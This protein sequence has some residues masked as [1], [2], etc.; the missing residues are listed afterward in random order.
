MNRSRR[1][2][3]GSLVFFLIAVLAVVGVTK[4]QGQRQVQKQPRIVA[5]TDALVAIAAKLDLKLVGVPKTANQL[6]KR[7][8]HVAKIG[9]PMAPNIEK[10]AALKPTDVYAVSVLK[11]QYSDAFKAQKFHPKFLSLNT[12]ADLKHTLTT[13]GQKFDRQKQAQHQIALIDAAQAQAKKRI[14]GPKTKVL[15][16][17]GMPG[18]GYMIATD[19]SYVGDL[20]KKAG[21]ENVYASAA[22][23][24][25]SPSNESL[26]TKR[27]DVIL[28]LEHALPNMV[29]PQ[30]DQEFKTNPLWAQMP[31][32]KNQRVYDLQQPDFNATA[33]IQAAV[34]LKRVSHWLYE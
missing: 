8:R 7:Y 34:A 23:E 27:P 3:V 19:H 31:A 25:L 28:R 15:I 2:L 18:A 9:S 22:G 1:I 5:T 20:V 12:I 17:M 14:H 29:K 13:L 24:Y 4:W 11:D 30:F 21:G 6:P 33:T 26:A 10:I 16:L 32:V